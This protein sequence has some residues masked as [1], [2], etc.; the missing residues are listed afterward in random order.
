MQAPPAFYLTLS[1]AGPPVFESSDCY[2]RCEANAFCTEARMSTES[3]T[4]APKNGQKMRSSQ[5]EGVFEIVFVNS[6]MQTA[7]IRPIDGTGH[8]VPNVPWT[9]L[10]PA[11][12]K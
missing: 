5:H 3:K 9:A 1:C 4:I 10:T 12:R 8:V 7:N 2:G 11:D 6:L